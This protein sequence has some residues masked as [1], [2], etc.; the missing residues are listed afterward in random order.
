MLSSL[1]F[2]VEE[3]AKSIRRNGLMSVTALSTVTIALAVFGGASYGLYRTHQFVH[4]Q[5]ERFHIAVF[6]RP[7]VPRADVIEVRN[8]I[9]QMPGVASA[10]L[11]TREEALEQMRREDE[12]RGV[13]VV[14]ALAGTNPLPDRLDVRVKNPS[15]TRKVSATLANAR[16]Y[17]EIECVRDEVDTVEK[18]LITSNLVRNVGGALAL[19]ML[20]ATHMVVQ[21]TLRLTVLA[22]K[23]AI[24]IMRLV[25]ATPAFIQFPLVLE[26]LFHGVVGSALAGG[27]VLF[28]AAQASQYASR[29]HT[30]LADTVPPAPAPI[31]VLG[32]MLLT[33]ALL[34]L[35]TSALAI[36]RFLR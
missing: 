32:A 20:L 18:L 10:K 17:P 24:A 12:A 31:V 28:V 16:R 4:A 30:P 19:L 35:I 1:A 33:G 27:V 13:R 23:D 26:G 21:N 2:L 3:A 6:F 5:P 11:V 22:R 9:L 8:R 15:E 25:G 14:A 7:E 34:G 29:F 36:R